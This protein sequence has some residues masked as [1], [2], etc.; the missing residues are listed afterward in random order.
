MLV[1][2]YNTGKNCHYVSQCHRNRQ[3]QPHV[4]GFTTCHFVNIL[5]ARWLC[6]T[7]VWACKSWNNSTVIW[8]L[9]FSAAEIEATVNK[10]VNHFLKYAH[11]KCVPRVKI[12]LKISYSHQCFSYTTCPICVQKRSCNQCPLIKTRNCIRIK[13][14]KVCCDTQLPWCTAIRSETAKHKSTII[15]SQQHDNDKICSILWA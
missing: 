4:I 3:C 11:Q 7:E 9:N 13:R 2:S 12:W 5:N 10:V 1:S 14:N 6:S 8:Y 15:N